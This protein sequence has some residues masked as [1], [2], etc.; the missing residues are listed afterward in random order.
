MILVLKM[1]SKIHQLNWSG[2]GLYFFATFLII[3]LVHLVIIGLYRFSIP[4]WFRLGNYY[5]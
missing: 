5:F 1:L 2:S 4:S 3:D